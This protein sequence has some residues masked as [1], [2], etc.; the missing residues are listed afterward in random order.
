MTGRLKAGLG[1]IVPCRLPGHAAFGRR[2]PRGAGD[3][4]VNPNV[5]CGVGWIAARLGFAETGSL[6]RFDPAWQWE[7]RTVLLFCQ[8]AEAFDQAESDR[9]CA[10][11]AR[12]LDQQDHPAAG[13]QRA[14]LR[15]RRCRVFGI[16]QYVGS[17]DQVVA[18]RQQALG[19]RITQDIDDANPTKG[20][21]ANLRFA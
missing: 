5:G 8:A 12:R 21:P 11:V 17:D 13:Q 3:D 7:K 1:K 2:R 15:Q 9:M 19:K 6:E 10:R 16:V 18:L 20:N 4:D 14:Q